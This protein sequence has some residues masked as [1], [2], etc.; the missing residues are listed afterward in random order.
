MQR[1]AQRHRRAGVRGDVV[2]ARAVRDQHA[3]GRLRARR[4]ARRRGDHDPRPLPLTSTARACRR[5]AAAKR[6]A[7][8]RGG[9]P[10]LRT[11][12]RGRRRGSRPAPVRPRARR[13]RRR[14]RARGRVPRV[15]ARDRDRRRPRV[16]V[17]RLGRRSARPARLTTVLRPSARTGQAICDNLSQGSPLDEGDR[18]GRTIDSRCGGAA[19]PLPP[20]AHAGEEDGQGA[21]LLAGDLRVHEHQRHPDPA[22]PLELRPLRQ[23]RGRLQHR[24]A[25]RRRSA[26]SC[27][28][29]ASTTSRS[30]APAGSERRS[31][32]RRSSPSTGST[33]R[34]SSTATPPRWDASSAAS[35]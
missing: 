23:A 20:G 19:E 8:P 4:P 22:R 14:R 29:R 31:R 10:P 3:D 15:P 26:R 12:D 5:S 2:D 35:R 34:P 33:S 1:E 17:L 11:R 30:S 21:D 28:R 25:A 9:L 13:H 27:A 32:A 6:H 7:L 16:H 18:V 24:L